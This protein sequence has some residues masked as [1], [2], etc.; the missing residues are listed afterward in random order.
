MIVAPNGADCALPHT[1]PRRRGSEHNRRGTEDLRPTPRRGVGLHGFIDRIV[2][3]TVLASPI[4]W[5]F[6][7]IDIGSFHDPFQP[8]C[9]GRTLA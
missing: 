4:G 7:A 9:S 3:V 2:M 5:A 1:G 6:A 8:H